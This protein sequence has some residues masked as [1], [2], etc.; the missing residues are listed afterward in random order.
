M[1]FLGISFAN[2]FFFRVKRS[3]WAHKWCIGYKSDGA[4]D[5]NLDPLQGFFFFKFCTMKEAKKYIE[6]TLMFFLEKNFFRANGSL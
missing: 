3:F 5:T 2:G 1:D 4:L 6:I